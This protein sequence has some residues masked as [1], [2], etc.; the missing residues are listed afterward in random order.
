M[1]D[2]TKNTTVKTMT[3][4]NMNPLTKSKVASKACAANTQQKSFQKP[5]QAFR[6]HLTHAASY[7]RVVIGFGSVVCLRKRLHR[8]EPRAWLKQSSVSHVCVIKTCLGKSQV[9]VEVKKDGCNSSY[10]TL[11]HAAERIFPAN[12]S[13]NNINNSKL[14]AVTSRPTTGQ[15]Q[16]SKTTFLS[17][18]TDVK[19]LLQVTELKLNNSS[20]NSTTA[21]VLFDTAC[22]NSWVSDSLAATLCLEGTALKLTPKGINTEELINTMVVQLTVIPHKDQDFKAFTVRHY[23]R[24]RLNVGSDIIDVKSMQ[25]DYPHRAVPGPLR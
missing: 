9:P 22:S 13:N 15:Q 20:S 12:T 7:A 21:L 16:P 18:V 2:L 14:D 17:S 25:E 4:D 10:N 1:H 24:E 3:A 8:S 6:Q 5:Q 23:V 11:I 19:G